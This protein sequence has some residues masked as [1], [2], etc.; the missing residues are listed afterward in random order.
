MSDSRPEVLTEEDVLRLF[1]VLGGERRLTRRLLKAL[2][3]TDINAVHAR[4][5]NLRGAEFAHAA[6]TPPSMSAT[7]YTG[8]SIWKRCARAVP[9]QRYPIT[10][11]ALWM[12]LC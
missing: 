7:G 2:K 12:A 3:I 8:Q 6:L 5:I 11:S 1:P 4:H 9:L 10:R